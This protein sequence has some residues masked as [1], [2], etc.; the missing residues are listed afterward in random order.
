MNSWTLMRWQDGEKIG[1]KL[2]NLPDQV[3]HMM[4]P[5]WNFWI[6]HHSLVSMWSVWRFYDHIIGNW[7]NHKRRHWWNTSCFRICHFCEFRVWSEPDRRV[8]TRTIHK[9][10]LVQQSQLHLMMENTNLSYYLQSLQSEKG[11]R[12]FLVNQTRFTRRKMTNL[13]NVSVFIAR[14]TTTNVQ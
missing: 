7:M 11:K 3:H 14:E 9:I 13:I 2:I 8:Y 5:K 10:V 6:A 12:N 4:G 1:G